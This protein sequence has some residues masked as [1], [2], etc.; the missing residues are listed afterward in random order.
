[1]ECIFVPLMNKA[2][3]C[4]GTNEDTTVNLEKCRQLLNRIFNDIHYSAMSVTA[5]YGAIYK[6]DFLNQLAIVYTKENKPFVADT[7]KKIEKEIGRNNADKEKGII[8][9]DVD[10]VIW[11]EEVLKPSEISRS[12]IADLLPSLEEE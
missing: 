6:N 2:L 3:I 1:M 8:K 7:L 12:Y 11:N 10:L 5:P 9:I 4:I